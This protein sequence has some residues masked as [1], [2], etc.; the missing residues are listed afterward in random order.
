MAL[1]VTKKAIGGMVKVSIPAGALVFYSSAA[2]KEN[3]HILQCSHMTPLS[4]T[5]SSR[6]TPCNL[7]NKQS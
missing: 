2:H 5:T 6:R 7:K 3:L 1:S 4:R